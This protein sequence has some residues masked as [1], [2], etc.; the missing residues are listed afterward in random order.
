MKAMIIPVTPY[1]QNCTVLWCTNTLRAAV[2]DPGGDLPL[3]EKSVSDQ[4]I[5]I[6]KVLLT[7]GHADHAGGA[8]ALARAWNAPIEG[9]HR[10][11]AFL[12]S[13]LD[14]PRQPIRGENCTPDR[15]LVDGDTVSLGQV[16][17]GVRHC[18]GHTPGH[19]VYF[20]KEGR[21]AVVGDVLFRGSVGRTDIPR[22]DHNQLIESIT[23]RLWPLGD[24]M[25]FVPGHG[26]MS[27]FGLEREINPYVSDLAI[28]WAREQARSEKVRF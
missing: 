16:Q 23:Q 7:H 17:L 11:E 28:E 10:D 1:R 14:D 18:P 26:P 27:T 20:S 9:P 8:V 3:I 25:H 5:R 2:I 21:L 19:V 4:G 6:E 15:W 22:G 13:N 24:D 12:L